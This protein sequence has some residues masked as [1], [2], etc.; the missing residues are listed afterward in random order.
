[1]Q[2]QIKGT[3]NEEIKIFPNPFYDKLLIKQITNEKVKN[4]SV[5][6]TD[7][8]GKIIFFIKTNQN[9]IELSNLN[10]P[11]GVYFLQLQN[12]S[13]KLIKE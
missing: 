1:A 9:V 6:I 13:Y 2:V 8:S 11:S 5:T 4:E 12:Q 10:W 3:L 7:I